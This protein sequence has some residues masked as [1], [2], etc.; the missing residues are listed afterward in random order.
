MFDTFSVEH[1]VR[2][3][4]RVSFALLTLPD[5]IKLIAFSDF[6]CFKAHLFLI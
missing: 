3:S 6:L 5:A 1:L 4:R 2:F